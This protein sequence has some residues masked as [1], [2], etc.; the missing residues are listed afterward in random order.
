M[1]DEEMQE[2]LSRHRARGRGGVG[3]RAEEPGPFLP[4]GYEETRCVCVCV[5]LHA[6]GRR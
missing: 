5:C 3:P 4:E 6:G 2:M 1:T